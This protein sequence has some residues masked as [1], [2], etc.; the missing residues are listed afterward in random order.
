MTLST[1]CQAL[2]WLTI[3]CVKGLPMFMVTAL[4]GICVV[5]LVMMLSASMAALFGAASVGRAIGI[6]FAIKLPF[7]FIVPPLVG[8]L[9]DIKGDYALAFLVMAGMLATACLCC[10]LAV[11]GTRKPTLLGPLSWRSGG[12]SDHK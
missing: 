3:L 9:F 6:C 1:F 2:A 11:F 10:V 5:P 8:H 7:L 12:R 4:M